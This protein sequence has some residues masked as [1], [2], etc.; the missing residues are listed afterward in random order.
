MSSESPAGTGFR[1]AHTGDPHPRG[2]AAPRGREGA[3]R[4]PILTT[5]SKPHHRALHD[6]GGRDRPKCFAKT[7]FYDVYAIEA[8]DVDHSAGED[9]FIIIG[10][11]DRKRV[12]VTAFT[13]RGMTI[14]IISARVARRHERFEYEKQIP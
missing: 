5:S 11:S 4:W 9:R 7:C 13:V 6:S 8:Y 12:I 14:R 2:A 1:P 10:R 3:H